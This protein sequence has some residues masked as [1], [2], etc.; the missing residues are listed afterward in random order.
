[1]A[2]SRKPT[3]CARNARAHKI[4]HRDHWFR[5]ALA[6]RDWDGA[7]KQA[8]SNAK[9][10]I[11][12]SYLTALVH[13]K[14]GDYER[15]AAEVKTVQESAARKGQQGLD[16]RLCLAQ[17]LLECGTG[18]ADAGLK[19]LA[20]AADKTKDD[21]AR[22][23]W[24]HGAYFMEFWGLGSLRANRLAVAEEA[25]L[26]ALAHDAGSVCGALG[27]QSCANARAVMRKP[28]ALPAWRSAA[29][30]RPTPAC[31]RRSCN[32]SAVRGA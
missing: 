18:D 31:S 3:R 4:N 7:L 11:M 8:R 14:K 15:P 30:A 32:S 21:Y 26:E 28:A 17:G 13:L 2:D 24:G 5:L 9:D 1:M 10:K 25:F 20:K 23:A 22:H 27:M 19:L 12:T 29:G 6:E 16:L